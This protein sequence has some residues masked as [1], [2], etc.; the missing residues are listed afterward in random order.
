MSCA[1]ALRLAAQITISSVSDTVGVHQ[2]YE[3]TIDHAASYPNNW[4]DVKV[5]IEF[6]GPETIHIDGFFYKEHV[7]K[8]RF[9]V[10]QTGHWSYGLTFTTP[11]NTNV[12]RGSFDCLPSITKGFLQR[13]PNNPF[14]L[15][16]PDGTVFNGVGIEDCVLDYN[17]NGTPL[18]DW[19]FDGGIRTG[20]YTGSRTDMATYMDAYGKKGAGFNLFRWTTDNCSFSLYKSITTNGNQYSVENGLFGDTLI[21]TLRTNQMRVWLTFFGPPV[22]AQINGSTPAEEAA[23]KRYLNYVVARYGAYVDIWELFNESSA[24]AYYYQ[25]MTAYIRTIDP[26]HRLI[27]VSDERPQLASIDINSPHWYEKE[28]ELES[29]ARAWQMISSRKI[30]NKPI[31]F[32]EQGNS[33]QCWDP[34]SA[35]RMRLRTWTSFF[36]QGILIFW[37]AAWAKDYQHPVAANIY[38]GPQERGYIRALQDYSAYAD[39]SAVPFNISPQNPDEVRAYGL[40]AKAATFGYFHHY[41]NHQSAVGTSF[42][43]RMRRPGTIYWINPVDNS[44]ISSYHLNYGS[45]VISSPPFKVDMAMRIDLDL[46]AS[47]NE[48]EKLDLLV[49]PNP[50]SAEILVN[51]NFNGTAAVWLYDLSGKMV[52]NYSS[53]HNDERMSVS[54]L[55]NGLYIYVVRSAERQASGKLLVQH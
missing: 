26:Y 41:T 32:G 4:D 22:F 8:V 35:L 28:S 34:S 45:Q 43:Y 10:P 27:S 23:V 19:G 44:T 13:H 15:I 16:Y 30:F 40:S 17:N 47:F 37:N 52:L 12:A 11:T 21:N 50:A 14:K 7:W 36:A 6:T 55:K 54:D 53:V 25:A 48:I 33:V 2:V 3:L 1:F 29:D 51:G 39:S 20:N 31:I 18:D 49:Y 5:S 42:K 24:S 46:D 9:N 38:L